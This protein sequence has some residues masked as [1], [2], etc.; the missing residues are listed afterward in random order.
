M[1]NIVVLGA[2]F[3]GLKAALK[4]E[5]K[6]KTLASSSDKASESKGDWSVILIDKNSYHTYTAALY[7][8]ASAYRWRGMASM[9][10]YGGS[11]EGRQKFEE[12]LA[13]YVCLPINQII[14]NKNITFVQDSV[15]GV[16]FWNNE[17]KLENGDSV[18]YEY[19]V[20]ALGSE[21]VYF[22]IKGAE[23]CCYTLKTLED[24][25]SIRR[26]IEKVFS[27]AV[28]GNP[29]KIVIVGGG[30]TGVE[31]IAEIATYT[32]CLARDH[33][34]NYA[35]VHISLLEARDTIL[36][37]SPKLQRDKSIKRLEKLGV[38]IL[39]NTRVQEVMSECV[40]FE[41]GEKCDADIVLWSGGIKGP[42]LLSAKGG[43]MKGLELNDEGFIVVD[44]FLQA[45]GLRKVFAIGDNAAFIDEATGSRT[46]ATAFIAEQQADAVSENIMRISTG[47]PLAEYKARTPGYVISCGGKYAVAYLFGLTFSGF[48]GWCVK[49]LIDL[50]YFLSLFSF[51]EALLLWL[52]E[53]RLFTKND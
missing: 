31:T 30:A 53:L 40:L 51:R 23:K 5:E 1:K 29:I 45:K 15:S 49:K 2:G 16:D 13:E 33:K 12:T 32:R 4:L 52:R 21:T 42:A 28:K 22:D 8:A 46:P 20:F 17:V 3:G 39:T 24:A 25:F 6:L 48:F 10:P 26:R 19:L 47:Q 50:K 38:E 35:D 11:P 43:K 37:S 9:S 18:R 34:L 36:S 41:D 44:K 27:N 7:E 14:S